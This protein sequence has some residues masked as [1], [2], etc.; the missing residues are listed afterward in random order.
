MTSRKKVG[1][2]AGAG[3][4]AA[5]D[6]VLRFVPFVATADEVRRFHGTGE[7]MRRSDADAAVG[8]YRTLLQRAEGTT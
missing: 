7:R 2:I 6:Q 5:A 8:F 4:G 1:I 3:L